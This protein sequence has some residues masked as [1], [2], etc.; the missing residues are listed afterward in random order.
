MSP[1][2]FWR[3]PFGEQGPLRLLSS[4]KGQIFIVF[5][6]TFFSVFALMLVNL[7]SLS[8]VKTRLGLG[9][10][11]YELLNDVLEVRR[12]EKNYLLYHDRDSLLEGT[13]YLKKIDS[14]ASE[15]SGDMIRVTGPDTFNSFVTNL[16]AYEQVMADYESSKNRPPEKEQIRLQGKALV[17]HAEQFLAIKQQ[18]IEKALLQTSTVPFAFMA[19]FGI[20]MI[21]VMKLISAGLLRP[22]GV[23]E[24]TTQR[25]AKGDYSPTSYQGL[26]TDEMFGLIQAFNRMAQELESNQE[27]LLQAR[28][29]A[30][31]GTFTAGIAHELN[32]PLN[33][34]SLTA[35]TLIEEY[36]EK[37]EPEAAELVNDILFQAE[38]AGEIVSNLLNFSRTEKPAFESLDV[39]EVVRSTV[40]L[41]KNQ[42]ML[43]GIKLDLDLPEGLPPIHGH[44]RQLQHVFMNLLQN[45][46]QAMPDGGTIAIGAHTSGPDFM[47][48]DI[49]DTGVG[50]K[51][52]LLQHI[53]EPFFT[54][55]SVGR[56]TGL[57]LAVGYSIV[58]RHGG[59]VDVSSEVGK[60]TVFSVFLPVARVGESTGTGSQERENATT[61]SHS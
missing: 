57:G 26:H 25:V 27:H 5:A 44:L 58:K 52:E 59:R 45:A 20:L 28:K 16:K 13:A 41:V 11:Y 47:R 7:W 34:I 17:D 31:L 19:V 33:N 50:I 18:R 32:N 14:L 6:L 35:E 4:I 23:L 51:P 49:R 24:A 54:T 55:K 30:A 10:R 61:P 1:F 2:R 29:I 37:L 36:R 48:F 43:A 56:G 8:T 21:L 22:L 42:I 46:I 38:R 3:F 39:K 60:G 40:A 15:L 12:F 9:E 53:F